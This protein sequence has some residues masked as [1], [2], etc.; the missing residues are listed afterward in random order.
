MGYSKIENLVDK[1]NKAKQVMDITST[2]EFDEY[3]R[4]I[5]KSGSINE[6]S[7]QVPS[8]SPANQGTASLTDDSYKFSKLPK[9][10]VE[11]IRKNPIDVNNNSSNDAI[12]ELAKR[13][14]SKM[15]LSENNHNPK[16]SE[17]MAS[18]N[19]NNPQGAPQVDY[20]LI[21]LIVN[22]AIKESLSEIKKSVIKE[23]VDSPSVKCLKLGNSIQFLDSDGN[24]YEAKLVFKKNIKKK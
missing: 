6:T 23:N 8:L 21:K 7:A 1:L 20:S 5:T 14:T 19:T 11:S 15:G 16:F 24:L 4:N 12:D 2:K 3:A 10:I 13:V 9:E 22:D 18:K 17:F